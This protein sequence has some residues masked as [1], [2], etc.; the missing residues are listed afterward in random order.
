[1]TRSNAPPSEA[2][3]SATSLPSEFRCLRQ[4]HPQLDA[5]EKSAA[6]DEFGGWG[7]NVQD[8]RARRHP[9]GGTIGDQTAAT[10]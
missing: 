9:L 8:A 1:M 7:F 4:V 5:V 10:V 6:F 3:S 2:A